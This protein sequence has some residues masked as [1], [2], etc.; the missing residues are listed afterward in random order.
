MRF[1]YY[2][3]T[4]HQRTLSGDSTLMAKDMKNEAGFSESGQYSIHALNERKVLKICMLRILVA[5]SFQC[6]Q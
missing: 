4:A 2:A 5:I 3:K 6:K 1:Q